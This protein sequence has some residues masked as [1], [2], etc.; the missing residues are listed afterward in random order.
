MLLHL[1]NLLYVLLRARVTLRLKYHLRIYNIVILILGN[2]FA[3]YSLLIIRW[4]VTYT[5]NPILFLLTLQ[6]LS[7]HSV[8]WT[9]ILAIWL[10]HHCHLR[11]EKWRPNNICWSIW[12]K[13]KIMMPLNCIVKPIFVWTRFRAI[14]LILIII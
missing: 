8:L 7:K 3:K 6:L 11:L 10:F 14:V 9:H 1:L 12:I 13:F 5:S 4:V 2:T